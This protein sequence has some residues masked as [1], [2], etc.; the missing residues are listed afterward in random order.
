MNG[1]LFDVAIAGGGTAGCAAA[2]ALRARGMS[3]VLLEKGA[4]GAMASGINFGGV[5]RQGR[6]AVPAT[7]FNQVMNWRHS[8]ASWARTS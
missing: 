2:R 1:G 7:F 3:V 8:P 4:C 6:E 5:R